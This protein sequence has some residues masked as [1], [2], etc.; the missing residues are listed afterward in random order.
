MIYIDYKS[1][2]NIIRKNIWYPKN[3]QHYFKLKIFLK[4]YFPKRM[5]N[6]T[7][8]SGYSD[9][10]QYTLKIVDYIHYFRYNK[11]H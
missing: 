3:I 7:E 4:L 10:F 8:K 2:I 9:I 5:A 11:L 1:E 6:P